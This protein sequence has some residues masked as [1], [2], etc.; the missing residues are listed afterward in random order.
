MINSV[1]DKHCVVAGLETI[2]LDR[3]WF[4]RHREALPRGS[5]WPRLHVVPVRY[6]H[7][8]ISA[9][10]QGIPAERRLYPQSEHVAD[11]RVVP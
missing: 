6:V 5:I 2:R 1:A 7:Y 11:R 4:R 8:H 9:C 3:L 10:R